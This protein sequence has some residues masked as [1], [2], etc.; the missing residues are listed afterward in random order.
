MFRAS[1]FCGNIRLEAKGPPAFRSRCHC[2]VCQ[3][4][5]GADSIPAVGFAKANVS[6]TTVDEEREHKDAV[7]VATKSPLFTR[8]RCKKCMGPAYFYS[9]DTSNSGK[10]SPREA[11]QF[12]WFPVNCVERDPETFRVPE[13]VRQAL[14]PTRHVCYESRVRDWVNDGAVKY[15]GIASD[16][17]ILDDYG[18]LLKDGAK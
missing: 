4:F 16:N 15:Q 5:S 8:Y 7:V 1:C 6:I 10:N 13:K 12:Y 14:E 9:Q 11:N 3:R 17:I 18:N 2:S